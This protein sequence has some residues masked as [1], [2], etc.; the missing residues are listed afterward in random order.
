MKRVLFIVLISLFAFAGGATAVRADADANLIHNPSFEEGGTMPDE[1]EFF[2]HPRNRS[3][4]SYPVAGYNGE[5]AVRVDVDRYRRGNV[6]WRFDAVPVESGQNYSFE[7]MVRSNRT[8]RV[9]ARFT[10]D[11]GSFTTT[12]LGSL[13]SN[14]TWK[15]FTAIVTVPDGVTHVSVQHIIRARG[16]LELDETVLALTHPTT[17]F[18]NDPEQ[19]PRNGNLEQAAQGNPAQPLAWSQNT[20][21]DLQATFTYP[22]PGVSGRAA[23]VEVAQ[24]VS[25]DAKW[26]F[27]RI[28]TVPGKIYRL[29]NRYQSNV[30]TNVTVEFQMSDGS[31]QY[32][33]L[34]D[35]APSATAWGTFVGEITVPANAVAFTA[36]Q[37]L[38]SNGSLVVDDYRLTE[39]PSF[40]R[41]MITLAF[42]DGYSSI[43]ENGRPIL[44]AAGITSSQYI[45]TSFPGEPGYMTWEQ[46]EQMRS[47][48]HIIEAHS[49]THADLTLLLPDQAWAEIRGSYD[50]LVAHGFSPRTFTYP[51]GAFNAS[52]KQQVR[53]AGF[54]GA[55]SVFSGFNTPHSD[56]YELRDQHIEST[57]TIVQ[58]EQWIQE[59]Q[60]NKTWLIL[61]LHE[62]NNSGDQYSNTPEVL[63][64][65]VNAI[66]QSEI[67]VVTLDQGID[68]MVP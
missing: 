25:G 8:I 21:G 51:F 11:D 40:T 46:I 19:L 53:D 12:Q 33:W 30:T 16:Y 29:T 64:G 56:K 20:W 34:G 61:E 4:V 39:L 48:G 60:N 43:Y 44:N 68:L 36:F 1:W 45:V 58:V 35:P 47:E 3:A 28:P 55:R 57:T 59:A 22:V 42:D 52:V 66:L 9:A 23:K 7:S 2:S 10:K 5:R 27:D 63:Q 13:E 32:A 26:Y 24:Y 14:G 15:A 6:L 31:F 54:I 62:Q 65:I 37:A 17:P 41:G 67:K 38:V 18:P 50:D 49:R